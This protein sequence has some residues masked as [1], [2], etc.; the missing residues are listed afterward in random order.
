MDIENDQE[1]NIR[2]NMKI[3]I[4]EPTSDSIENRF[5]R[6]NASIKGIEN[7]IENRFNYFDGSLKY[8]RDEMTDM[9]S[10]LWLFFQPQNQRKS[11]SEINIENQSVIEDEVEL[12]GGIDIPS[13]S[14]N[15]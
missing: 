3:V 13:S 7:R 6:I 9:K 1:Q 4:P 5:N 8:L 14:G 15:A 11:E 2:I 12:P 10:D